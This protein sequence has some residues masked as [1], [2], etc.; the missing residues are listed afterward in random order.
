M[1]TN[2]IKSESSS[3]LLFLLGW[4]CRDGVSEALIEVLLET[5]V[6]VLAVDLAGDLRLVF[7]DFDAIPARVKF[8]GF[9]ISSVVSK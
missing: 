7:L 4:L 9:C 6:A 8:Y 2:P 3:F 5:D 1:G